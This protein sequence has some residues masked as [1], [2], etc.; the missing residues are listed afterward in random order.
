[1]TGNIRLIGCLLAACFV[2]GGC[3]EAEQRKTKL[4]D[5]VN[6]D[7]N[8]PDA[9]FELGQIYQK[10]KKWDLSEYYYDFALGFD[11]AP[12]DAQVRTVK[13]FSDGGDKTQAAQYANRYIGQ[14]SGSAADSLRLGLAFEKAGLDEYAI[15][16][17][18]QAMALAPDSARVQKVIGYYYSRNNDDATARQ[19][20]SRS[21]QL[22]PKQSLVAIELGRLG[23]SVQIPPE[24]KKVQKGN[25]AKQAGK[26]K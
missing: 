6:K 19:Y 11:L 25:G 10:E 12:Q 21:F 5:L 18:K 13:S 14:V 22:N 24:A 16:S 8:H 4:L 2:L 17:Y 26:T 7:H 1:M 15:T 3:S 20:L 9:H 23:V